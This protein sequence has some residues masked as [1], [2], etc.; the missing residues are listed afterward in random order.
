M[1]S[2]LRLSS[3]VINL[4]LPFVVETVH[5]VDEA[6]VAV[7]PVADLLVEPRVKCSV[8][9]SSGSSVIIRTF[10]KC[11]NI[12]NA[13]VV[14]A[15]SKVLQV[16]NGSLPGIILALGK[17]L[18]ICNLVLA[19]IILTLSEGVQSSNLSLPGSVLRVELFVE[20]CN[21]RDSGLVVLS[22]LLLQRLDL[23]LTEIIF[24]GG[25]HLQSIVILPQLVMVSSECVNL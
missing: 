9:S 1:H 4:I 18:Q 7:L 6:I 5:S 25:G 21:V 3:Q 2:P 13:S 22:L 14:L 8:L 17:V 24:S 19:C 11:S 15:L 23:I 16:S 12:S 20:L 10:V